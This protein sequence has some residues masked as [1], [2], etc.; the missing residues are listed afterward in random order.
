MPGHGLSWLRLQVLVDNTPNPRLRGEWG[1]SLYLEAP[2]WRAIFD[3]DTSPS[4]LEENARE[5]GARLDRLDWGFLSHHHLDHK[6]GYPAVARA[7]PGLPVYVPPGCDGSMRRW[8]LEP[9]VA[10]TPQP[11][12]EAGG[13]AWTSG[14]LHAGAWGLWEHALAV[15]LEGGAAVVV[16]GCSHPGADRL[17]EEAARAAGVGRLLAVIGG[18]H[19]PSR[20][21]LDRL[22]GMAERVCPT[23]CSGEEAV[24]YLERRHPDKLCLARTGTTI[25]ATPAGLVVESY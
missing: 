2:G 6:G 17:V 10:R 11:I 20:G 7:R 25:R 1:W 18:F 13:A 23:H 5:L 19:G 14:A 16:V 22:A 9:R 15:I 4:R 8:G 12:P 3:A 24:R 21:V